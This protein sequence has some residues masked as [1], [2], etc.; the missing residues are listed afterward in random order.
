MQKIVFVGIIL[1]I[2][3]FSLQFSLAPYYTKSFKAQEIAA[4]PK[5]EVISPVN[6]IERNCR[7]IYV[8]PQDTIIEVQLQPAF[9]L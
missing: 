1:V 9:N 6:Y 2:G 7:I 5:S 3:L 4:S 8:H